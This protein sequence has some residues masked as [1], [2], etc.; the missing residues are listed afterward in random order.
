MEASQENVRYFNNNYVCEKQYPHTIQMPASK[1]KTVYIKQHLTHQ[2]EYDP[3]S[4]IC[5]LP[6]KYL[7]TDMFFGSPPRQAAKCIK[8]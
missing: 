8:F 7:T 2:T 5:G 6:N 4:N 3:Q 1:L